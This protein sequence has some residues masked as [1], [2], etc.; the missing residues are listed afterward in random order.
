MFRQVLSS[1]FMTVVHVQQQ[2]SLGLTLEGSSRS[3][4]TRPF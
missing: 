1:N 4:A 3:A 2:V